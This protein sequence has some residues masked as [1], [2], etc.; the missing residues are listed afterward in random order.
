MRFQS[1][2]S[3]TS[4]SRAV[5]A[6]RWLATGFST[7]ISVEVWFLNNRMRPTTTLLLP[8]TP[9]RRATDEIADQRRNHW[10]RR[11]EAPEKFDSVGCTQ[12]LVGVTG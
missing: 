2:L 12:E 4:A 1:S 8:L 9:A 10:Q 7:W 5:A 6:L 11:D 3:E